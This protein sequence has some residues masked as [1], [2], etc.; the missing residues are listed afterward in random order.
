V[1][2]RT[3]IATNNNVILRSAPEARVS[4]DDG[5]D[6]ATP[7]RSRFV[8]PNSTIVLDP[9]H[10]LCAACQ[11]KPQHRDLAEDSSLLSFPLAALA[12]D[13]RAGVLLMQRLTNAAEHNSLVNISENTSARLA[14]CDGAQAASN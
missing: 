8:D 10:P 11:T 7:R 14:V 9:P 13:E 6:F 3:N 5:C 1:P 2:T 12:A 4:K